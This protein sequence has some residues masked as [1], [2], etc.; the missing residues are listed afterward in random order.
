MTPDLRSYDV[1]L[2]NSSAGKD[3][4]AML[5][6]VWGR[7]VLA[8]VAD[9]VVVVHADLGRME[10]PGT[11]ELARLQ[12]ELY[13]ARF[14]V[15]R[16]TGCD[17]LAR[18]LD[19]FRKDRAAGK[20]RPPWFDKAR[21][22]CTSD[23]KRGPVRTLMTRLADEHREARGPKS[24]CRILNCMGMRA[25]ESDK[26]AKMVA[27]ERDDKASNG[28]RAVD[29]WLPIHDWDVDRVWARIRTSGVPH[30]PAY[31]MGMKRLSCVFCIYAPRP[32]LMLA[33]SLNPGLLS[34]YVE[35]EH[36]TGYEFVRGLSLTSVQ[37]ALAAGEAPPVTAD[38]AMC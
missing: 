33:G 36:Q 15:V 13:G 20:V 2:V 14:E 23:F 9:R 12:A 19:K 17:L 31:D 32:A 6:E 25:Q 10:W 26:R 28:R 8:G 5:D 35:V 4:Q 1:I 22:W 29:T 7:A 11:K 24:V 21:R 37:E 38:W 34:E 30:H 27:F 3:S 16:R 18:V